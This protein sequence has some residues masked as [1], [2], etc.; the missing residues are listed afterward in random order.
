MTKRIDFPG[1][2]LPAEIMKY[3]DMQECIRELVRRGITY[4]EINKWY[5][6]L[7]TEHRTR[8]ANKRKYLDGWYNDNECQL[9]WDCLNKRDWIKLK[10]LHREHVNG[11]ECPVCQ[12]LRIKDKL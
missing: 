4:K 8:A 5:R 3:K 1:L 9:Y 11:E 6:E 12:I 7:K 2:E 10:S